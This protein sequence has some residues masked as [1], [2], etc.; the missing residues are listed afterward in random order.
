MKSRFSLTVSRIRL[1]LDRS[2]FMSAMFVRIRSRTSAMAL[3]C[4]VV[5]KGLDEL[6]MAGGVL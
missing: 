4:A 5:V 3:G 2:F 1:A 6:M